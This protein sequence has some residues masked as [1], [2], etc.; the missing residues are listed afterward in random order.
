MEVV[1]QECASNVLQTLAYRVAGIQQDPHKPCVNEFIPEKTV[2]GK[3]GT[4]AKDVTWDKQKNRAS[5]RCLVYPYGTNQNCSR[6][7]Q[8]NMSHNIQTLWIDKK[9]GD[10]NRLCLES[11]LR[12]GS[13]VHLY[14]YGPIE[15]V[16]Q[17]V[18]LLDA[19][20]ILDR[21]LIFKDHHK[22]YA[23][24]SDWFRVKLLYYLGG[25]WSDADVFCLKPFESEMPFVY[26]TEKVIDFNGQSSIAVCNCVIKMK[27]HSEIGSSLLSN[28]ERQI[29]K[30]GPTKLRWT[31]IGARALSAEII[32]HDQLNYVVKPEVFCPISYS[33]FDQIFK[34]IN[35]L[36]QEKT[37]GIHL[38]NQMWTWAEREITENSDFQK[39]Q[40]TFNSK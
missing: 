38:W 6:P 25:W 23:T 15:N 4:I 34:N 12:R 36:D 31:D 1:G 2:C 7:N 14:A 11:F 26:A 5:I 17:K 22:S 29:N 13:E 28:V 24:F 21:S 35:N 32:E 37:F 30:F 27:K 39:F 40:Q 3:L 33:D 8:L 10:H 18:T 16:P 9:L 20:K 19:N